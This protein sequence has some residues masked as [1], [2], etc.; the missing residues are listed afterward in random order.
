VRPSYGPRNDRRG[1]S[2]A[3]KACQEPSKSVGGS[4]SKY[5]LG[6]S[7]WG[8]FGVVVG[9]A[10]EGVEATLEPEAGRGW[11]HFGVVEEAVE[12]RRGQGF[13]AEGLC[14]FGDGP[15]AGHDGG[16]ARRGQRVGMEHVLAKRALA[17]DVRA[18]DGLG[19]VIKQLPPNTAGVRERCA[20]TRP[21]G[22]EILGA[23]QSAE[24]V[25]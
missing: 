13:V 22:D 8:R 14:P 9:A 2:A 15:V 25:S 20:V 7:G 19:A 23:D 1:K 12:D 21:K 24:R 4:P 11:E 10:A 5:V 6:G 18:N 16:A 3:V 17:P